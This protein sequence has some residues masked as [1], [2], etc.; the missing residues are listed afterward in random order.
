MRGADQGIRFD[1]DLADRD[2]DGRLDKS[3]FVVVMFLVR[4]RLAGQALPESVPPALF[5]PASVETTSSAGTGSGQQSVVATPE[6]MGSV[7]IV[8]EQARSDEPPPP[9]QENIPAE[10]SMS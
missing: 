1:R 2:G 7:P 10:T 3:E 5:E 4:G 6:M 8:E 9:Y